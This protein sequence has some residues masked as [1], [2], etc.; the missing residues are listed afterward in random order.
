[1]V[2]GLESV[3]IETANGRS[4]RLSRGPGGLRAHAREPHEK[5][6]EWTLPG[7][8]RGESGVLGEGIRQALLRDPSYVPALRRRAGDGRLSRRTRDE[9][10]PPD[11]LP[12]RRLRGRPG[13]GP[14]AA[15]W[16]SRRASSAAWPTW[17]SAAVARPNSPTGCSVKS[18]APWRTPSGGSPTSAACRPTTPRATTGWRSRRCWARRGSSPSRSTAWRASL[19]PAEGAGRYEAEL[20]RLGTDGEPVTLD[21][22]VL[23]IGPD[24]AHRL[25]VPRR[26]H[27]RPR[28]TPCAWGS[29][30]RP[31]RHPSGSR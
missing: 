10:D 11:E 15:W 19:G 27:A 18:R 1:M 21:V 8:S 12:R 28:S 24:G 13:G 9:H 4:L 5:S 14:R 29:R 3:S 6:R 20:R 17:P 30:T 22:V 7:A 25:P 23:G 16:S 2:P 31:S 26:G